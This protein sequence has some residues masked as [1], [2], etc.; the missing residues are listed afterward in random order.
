[1]FEKQKFKIG[2]MVLMILVLVSAG[3]M[4][5][6]SKPKEKKEVSTYI[7]KD[8]KV[9]KSNPS[10]ENDELVDST[11]EESSTQ[12]STVDTEEE[13]TPSFST[14]EDT[15]KKFIIKSLNFDG[16]SSLS[17]AEDISTDEVLEKLKTD[18]EKNKR[19]MI[20]D[21]QLND[22]WNINGKQG[23]VF[24]YMTDDG[25]K[26]V[27]ANALITVNMDSNGVTK[28]SSYEWSFNG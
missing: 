10:I 1:M 7:T 11:V 2:L 8:E 25:T 14:L 17:N 19:L 26:K 9:V 23:Y 5:F 27:Q 24:F 15:A 28:I 22:K 21:V 16:Q 4:L 6:L 12:S 20:T 13:I 18:V 3:T